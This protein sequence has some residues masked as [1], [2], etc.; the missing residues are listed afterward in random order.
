MFYEEG[1]LLERGG[2]VMGRVYTWGQ[3]SVLAFF[4]LV[5]LL[6]MSYSSMNLI[7]L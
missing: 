6:T 1:L 7:L 3:F 5:C 4:T 2:G